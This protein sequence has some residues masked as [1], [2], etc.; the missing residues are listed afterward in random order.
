LES[1][2]EAG[3][4]TNTEGSGVLVQRERGGHNAEPTDELEGSESRG[5]FEVGSEKG[6]HVGGYGSG[7]DSL[8]VNQNDGGVV[9]LGHGVAGRGGIFDEDGPDG[10]PEGGNCIGV[11]GTGVIVTRGIIFEDLSFTADDGSGCVQVSSTHPIGSIPFGNLSGG[12]NQ[13]PKG[14]GIRNGAANP[15]ILP[16]EDS[17]RGTLTKGQVK[18][19][20]T[21]EASQLSDYV[22]VEALGLV[23]PFAEVVL[24]FLTAVDGSIKENEVTIQTGEGTHGTRGDPVTSKLAASPRGVGQG[25]DGGLA[26]G[27]VEGPEDIV[28]VVVE[29]EVG[30]G[31]GARVVDFEGGGA[32]DQFEDGGGDGDGDGGDLAVSEVMVALASEHGVHGVGFFKR[33]SNQQKNNNK[34]N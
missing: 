18:V 17:T 14:V 13:T 29:G 16:R 5:T 34:K 3:I 33:T 10:A 12:A 1:K 22:S 7:G 21:V 26:S 24:V 9:G 31:G 23:H 27:A 19:E 15:T 32:R 11:R 20:G 2:G 28:R 4:G 30:G 8:S 6:G 25:E